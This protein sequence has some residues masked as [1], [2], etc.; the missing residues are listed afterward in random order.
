MERICDLHMHFLPGMDDGCKTPEESL[1]VLQ[2]SYRQGI[3]RVFATSH[4]YPVEPVA[5][6]LQRREEAVSRLEAHIRSQEVQ[7]IPQICLGAEVAYRPGLG[8]QENIEQLC[9]GASRYLLLEMPFTRWGKTEVRE[10]GRLIATAG[11][12]PVL[13]HIERYFDHQDKSVLMAILEQDVL[14]QMNV[15]PLL[16]RSARRGAMKLLEGGV[17]QL[18]GTDCHNM[19]DRSPKLQEALSFLQ[20][21]KMFG[22]LSSIA[23]F[24]DQVFREAVATPG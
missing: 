8:Q 19:K 6:F 24:S 16:D 22:V 23:H 1:Q 4:Y 14:V 17:V 2:A 21:K 18:L 7:D 11:V 3:K 15:G 9:L 13:A 10:V 5:A 20:K 12:T